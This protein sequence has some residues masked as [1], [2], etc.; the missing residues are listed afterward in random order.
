MHAKIVFKINVCANIQ[1]H[2]ASLL[3]ITYC[4]PAYLKQIYRLSALYS[5]TSG[6]K[7]KKKVNKR[8]KLLKKKKERKIKKEKRKKKK[9]LLGIVKYKKDVKS[10]QKVALEVFLDNFSYFNS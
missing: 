9:R 8:G 4:S 2:I 3:A 5:N 6:E 7:K 10:M 1:E